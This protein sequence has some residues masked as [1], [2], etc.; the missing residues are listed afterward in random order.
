[1]LS[2]WE[3]ALGNNDI[4]IASWEFYNTCTKRALIIRGFMEVQH[5]NNLMC[6]AVSEE[7]LQNM[8]KPP[9]ACASQSS[10]GFVQR[11]LSQLTELNYAVFYM[12]QCF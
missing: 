11:K 6:S 7:E 1:M 3:M 12:H 4:C 5:C 8:P 9:K 2:A 10:L